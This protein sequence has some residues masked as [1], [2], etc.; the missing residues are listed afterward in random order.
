MESIFENRDAL[1]LISQILFIILPVAVSWFAR[2]YLKNSAAEKQIGSIVRLA[3]AA[4]DYVENLDKRGDLV[5]APNARRS[6][7]KLNH[8]A[9]WLEGE[10]ENNGIKISTEEAR[11]WISSEYQKRVGDPRPASE[12]YAHARAAV[13]M[14]QA[15]EGERFGEL[16]QRPDRLA[17]LANMAAD[18]VVSQL[19][20]SRSARITHAEALSCINAEVLGRV[21]LQEAGEVGGQ[22][23]AGQDLAGQDLASQVAAL[24]RELKN[25]SILDAQ[26]AG[27]G[28]K[29]AE[30][31]YHGSVIV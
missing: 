7:V 29:L 2:T 27:N 19:A 13:D 24:L 10:L 4:I 26:G 5:L 31:T 11:E 28:F 8:A 12:M 16:F 21:R 14:I 22:D 30:N 25:H 20:R 18:W 6:I 1:D 17:F 15:V 9:K 3:N 23:L